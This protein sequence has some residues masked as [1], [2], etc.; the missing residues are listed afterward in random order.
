MQNST[1]WRADVTDT[2]L[3]SWKQQGFTV[4]RLAE[5]TGL[6]ISAI[7]LRL[8]D[9]Y[10]RQ[11]GDPDEETIAQRCDEIQREWSDDVRL[12][13]WVGRGGRWSAT[14]VPGSVVQSALRSRHG[15]GEL[16]ESTLT[17]AQ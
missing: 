4:E 9:L 11:W 7:S 13:R 17:Y 12:K 14:G 2:Q 16:P 15:C 5:M 3:L 10:T 1:R 6:T 8:Q